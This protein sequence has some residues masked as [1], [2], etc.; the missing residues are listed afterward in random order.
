MRQP[1]QHTGSKSISL[2]LQILRNLPNSSLIKLSLDTLPGLT[3]DRM[4]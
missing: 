4:L 3:K 2:R 1:L